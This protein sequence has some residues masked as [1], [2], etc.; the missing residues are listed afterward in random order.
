MTHSV[1][2]INV[3]IVVAHAPLPSR[4]ALRDFEIVTLLCIAASAAPHLAALVEN[5]GAVRCCGCRRALAELAV[6]EMMM[7]IVASI[8]DGG[9][10]SHTCPDS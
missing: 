7:S 3:D 10:I 9:I 8:G 1:L 6:D 2:S 5:S 4:A